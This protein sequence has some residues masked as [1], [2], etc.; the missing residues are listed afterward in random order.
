MTRRLVATAIVAT[1]A[2]ATLGGLPAAADT[3]RLVLHY[4]FDGDLTGGTVTDRSG[5]GLHGTLAAPA[6][7]RTTAH[8]P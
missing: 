7:A 8:R 3:G 5:S 6:A 2:A 4:D 1:L